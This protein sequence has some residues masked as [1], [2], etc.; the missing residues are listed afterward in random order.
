M[1]LSGCYGVKHRGYGEVVVSKDTKTQNVVA[2]KRIKPTLNSEGMEREVN[3]LKECESEY[4]VR[5]IG[6]QRSENVLQVG[7]A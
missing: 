6:L 1:G 4:L 5:V 3:I 7:L 2:L